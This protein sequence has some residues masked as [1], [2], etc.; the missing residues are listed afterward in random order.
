MAVLDPPA[1]AHSAL[2]ELAEYGLFKNASLRTTFFDGVD[3]IPDT[4]VVVVV[5]DGAAPV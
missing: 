5:S 2:Y 4:V 1:R 3:G